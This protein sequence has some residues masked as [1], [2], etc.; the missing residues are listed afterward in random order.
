MLPVPFVPGTV[1]QNFKL[2]LEYDGSA[3]FGFQKQ[4]A[5]PTIQSALEQALEKL[6]NRKVKIKS[7]SGRTDSGVHAEGQVAH[8]AVT[9]WLSLP[10]IQKALNAI[11]PRDVVVRSVAIAPP[12][13]HART[14]AKSKWY[15]YQI[16]NNPVR[17]LFGRERMHYLAERLDLR[18]MRRAARPLT[19]RRDFK[20][21]ASSGSSP[22]RTTVR[23]L[24]LKIT[25]KGPLVTLDFRANG[26]LYHMARRITGYLIEIG[27]GRPAPAIPPS[28]AAKGLCLLEVRY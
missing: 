24:R 2:V 6:F 7:A 3:F 19:G 18:K 20:R 23:T 1:P 21:F 4:A 16:W 27:K 5:R 9:S 17:P 11:L 22:V 26:F 13:F 28:A 10:E 8:A 25:R 15:R 12:K 14:S